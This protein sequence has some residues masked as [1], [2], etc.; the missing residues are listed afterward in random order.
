MPE[1]ALAERMPLEVWGHVLQFMG[2]WWNFAQ[3]AMAT[4][5]CAEIARFFRRHQSLSALRTVA[6]CVDLWE[7][8]LSDDETKM[9]KIPDIWEHIKI[10]CQATA[11]MAFSCGTHAPKDSKKPPTTIPSLHPCGTSSGSVVP[12]GSV[13]VPWVSNTWT[14]PK[15]PRSSSWRTGFTIPG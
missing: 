10:P 11:A 4:K 5:E 14:F 13:R 15:T 9:P 7:L 8:N 6:R 1:L 3:F 2:T 12:G